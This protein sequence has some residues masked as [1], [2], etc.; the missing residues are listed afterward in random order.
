MIKASPNPGHESPSAQLETLLITPLKASGISTIIVIDALDEC[1]DENSSS[2]ILS[3]LGR[4]IDDLSSIKF[5]ITSRPE[6]HI[7]SGFHLA[8]RSQAD[9]FLLHEVDRKSVDHDIRLYLQAQL[10]EVAESRSEIKFPVPWPDEV[11][12][13]LLVQKAGGLFVFASTM[14]KVI[15]ARPGNPHKLLQQILHMDSRSESEGTFGLDTL[16]TQIL[17]ENHKNSHPLLTPQ[18]K[19]V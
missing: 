1:E 7:K 8:L 19:L 17:T 10:A 3:L 13:D 15:S 5:F 11:S 18:T 4:H 2:A 14:C 6:S 9:V 16:Y 12:I